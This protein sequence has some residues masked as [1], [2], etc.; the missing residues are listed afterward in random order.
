[1]QA[2]FS[3]T[4]VPIQETDGLLCVQVAS[5]T[6]APDVPVKLCEGR[7][8]HEDHPGNQVIEVRQGQQANQG[9]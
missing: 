9:N 2:S 5:V 4:G 3:G 8:A 1:M 6:D 7:Q